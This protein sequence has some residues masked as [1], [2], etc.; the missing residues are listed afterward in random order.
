MI[1]NGMCVVRMSDCSLMPSE[2]FFSYICTMY[3]K[4]KTRYISMRWW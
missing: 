3:I 1:L 4:M 2:Q